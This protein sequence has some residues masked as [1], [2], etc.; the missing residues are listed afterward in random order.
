MGV[1]AGR[2]HVEVVDRISPELP[3]W[4]AFRPSISG[5]RVSFFEVAWCARTR[6]VGAKNAIWL[7]THAPQQKNLRQRMPRASYSI[8]SFT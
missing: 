2:V 1:A 7:E 6:P 5:S 8:T 3:Y 4:A